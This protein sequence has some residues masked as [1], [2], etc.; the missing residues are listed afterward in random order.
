M[1]RRSLRTIGV[2]LGA[3]LLTILLTVPGSWARLTHGLGN[4][5]REGETRSIKDTLKFFSATIGGFYMSGGSLSGL[6]LFPATSSVKRRILLDL[7]TLADANTVL[8]ADRDRSTV[9]EVLFPGP[10]SA[11]AIVDEAWFMQYQN[12][13]TRKAVSEKKA[14]F[15]TVRYSLKKN[16]GKWLVSDYEVFGMGEPLPPP[17]RERPVS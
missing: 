15:I 4:Y 1:H 16:W 14:N 2:A 10:D 13:A 12:A 17:R 9:R 6:N 5:D 7:R 11:V 8:V 3:A